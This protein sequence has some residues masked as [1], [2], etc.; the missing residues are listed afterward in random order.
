MISTAPSQNCG[1]T[2]ATISRPRM[3]TPTTMP[4]R[5]R[6]A[7]WTMDPVTA[8]I[9]ATA[10]E[11]AASASVRGSCAARRSATG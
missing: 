6:D 9:H 1:I 3:T 10:S 11:I 5:P 2:L 8:M 7:A 4:A